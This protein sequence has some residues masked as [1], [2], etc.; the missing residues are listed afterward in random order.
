[1]RHFAKFSLAVLVFAFTQVSNV[2]ADAIPYPTPGI[3]NPITYTFTALNTGDVIAYFA[4]SAAAFD[5]VLGMEVNG[6]LSL[7]GFGLDN[8]TSAVGDSF[9]LGHANAG[10]TLTFVM[11]NVSPGLG[12]LYSDPTRNGPY[13]NGASHNH[14]YST[15]YTTTGPVFPGV[16]AGIYVA[17][18]DLPGQDP[19]PFARDWNYF[20]ETFVFTNVASIGTNQ[21]APLPSTAACGGFLIAGLLLARRSVHRPLAVV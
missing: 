20:D 2:K 5:N 8:Q 11:H 16:P 18:E 21:N 4:G 12:D 6:V 19:T 17:F 1:M 9:N 3:E 13:D 7:N 10:D 15:L 14:I